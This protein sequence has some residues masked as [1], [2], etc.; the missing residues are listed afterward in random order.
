MVDDLLY[1]SRAESTAAARRAAVIV[2]RDHFPLV[3]EHRTV[4][5]HLNKRRRRRRLNLYVAN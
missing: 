5:I 4:R 3:K 1:L 2:V